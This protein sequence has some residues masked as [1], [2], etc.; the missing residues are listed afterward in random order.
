MRTW[1]LTGVLIVALGG[2]AAVGVLA[3]PGGS[4]GDSQGNDALSPPATIEEPTDDGALSPPATVEDEDDGEDD[5]DVHDGDVHGV[6]E[7]SPACDNHED[8]DGD[9]DGC[10]TVTNCGGQDLH[11]PQP[12]VD[13]MKGDDCDE[14]DGDVSDVD[15]ANED[16]GS[17]E[18]HGHGRPDDVPRGGHHSDGDEEDD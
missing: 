17:D 16:D 11:L 1:I 2:F 15:D 14:E 9:G 8:T 10:G 3:G 6:P 7:D 4:D 18:N 5:G 13:N 12:A